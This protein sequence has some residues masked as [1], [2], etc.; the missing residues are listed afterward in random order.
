MDDSQV[1]C[2]MAADMQCNRS[3]LVILEQYSSLG[4]MG[5]LMPPVGIV[6]HCACCG[7]GIMAGDAMAADGAAPRAPGGGVRSAA[8]TAGVA[9]TGVA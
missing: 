8:G 6:G 1:Y 3:W 9:G 4:T 7:A 2:I 5:T